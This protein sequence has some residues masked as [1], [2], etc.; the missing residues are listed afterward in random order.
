MKN[1]GAYYIGGYFHLYKA[2]TQEKNF[3]GGGSTTPY[4]RSMY[5]IK[6]TRETIAEALKDCTSGKD[7][8]KRYSGAFEA[9][10]RNG[11][12]DL[13][14]LLPTQSSNLGN[15]GQAQAKWTRE[16]LAAVI[17]TCTSGNEFKRRYAGAYD[18]LR[19]KG[20]KDLLDLLPT[21]T[22]GYTHPASRPKYTKSYIK[23]L[24][25]SCHSQFEF[26]NQYPQANA[27]LLKNRWNYLLDGLPYYA[28]RKDEYPI[29]CVYKWTFI[30]TGAVYIGLTSNYERRIKEEYRYKDSSPVKQYIEETGCSF[31]IE[32]LE[33]GLYSHEAAELERKYISEYRSTGVTVLNKNPGGSLGGYNLKTEDPRSDDDILNEIF[34][35]YKSYKELTH[36]GRALYKIVQKRKLY[37]RVW[38]RLPKDPSVKYG[39]DY[40]SSIIDKCTTFSEF[41]S[42]SPQEYKYMSHKGICHMLSSLDRTVELPK[43][44]G[45]DDTVALVNAGKLTR[46]AAAQC[47]GI[48]VKR[49]YGLG[50]GTLKPAH[51]IREL[52]RMEN[53]ALR[54]A[55]KNEK[56][57][58]KKQDKR[59]S[60]RAELLG[61]VESKYTKLSELRNDKNLYT[62][63]KRYGLYSIVSAKLEHKNRI[64]VTRDDVSL[65]VSKCRTYAQFMKDYPSEYVVARRNRWEDLLEPLS[66]SYTKSA[67]ITL[68]RIK[69][70]IGQC[71][72]RTE[73][74][75]RFISEY[76]AAKKRG[77]YDELVK[78]MPK[79]YG[80]V[81]P[82]ADPV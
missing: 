27:K 18:A 69:E 34:S 33:M 57:I 65:A 21:H 77:I 1:I 26:R 41:K 44:D 38:E 66:R 63:I 2:R 12:E 9:M 58:E 62:Q 29:W 50:R 46:K 32:R 54:L 45:F 78:D 60:K 35:K 19:R 74:S 6:W 64:E 70:C 49:L 82:L 51:E 37:E 7:F 79:Q 56:K 13:K 31:K 24:I 42:K 47:L 20:W 55:K 53:D 73:F 76:N 22:P 5:K 8:K 61:L 48:T 16:S 81:K 11:W 68:E 75:K 17:K 59:Q 39:I 3:M 30:E 23:D 71:A 25:S 28:E 72:S 4:R 43:P 80:K 67:D 40:L 15:T 52:T 10:K 36:T 14:A